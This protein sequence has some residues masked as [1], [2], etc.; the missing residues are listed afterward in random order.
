MTGRITPR[1]FHEAVGVVDWR[2][3]GEA[4][5]EHF[6]TGSFGTGVALVDAIG[7]LAAAANRQPDVDLRYGGVT[8]RGR[9]GWRS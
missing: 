9:R 3:V 4:A 2:D 7:R 8:V 6:R 1:R 5:C